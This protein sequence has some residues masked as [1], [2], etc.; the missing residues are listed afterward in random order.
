MRVHHG[1]SMYRT[2]AILT[3]PVLI[4]T[5]CG[6]PRLVEV[7]DETGRIARAGTTTDRL[8]TG[9]W[10]YFHAN[11]AKKAEG[12]WVQDKQE[13]LWTWWNDQGQVEIRGSYLHGLRTGPWERFHPSGS[14]SATG[15]YQ[16][17][18][19]HGLWT[20]RDPAGQMRSRGTFHRG[21]ERGLWQLGDEHAG[22][23]WDGV[24]VGPW[25]YRNPGGTPILVELP[26]P[27]GQTARWVLQDGVPV[28]EVPG[29]GLRLEWPTADGSL[30]FRW[31]QGDQGDEGRM[32]VAGA[33]PLPSALIPPPPA[34]S[35]PQLP[36]AAPVPVVPTPE[37]PV[38]RSPSPTQPALLTERER[39]VAQ[40]LISTYT[41]GQNPF[42]VSEYEVSSGP[43]QVGG[44]PAG[45]SLL[46]RVLPQQR[47]LSSTG[48][49][50]DLAA[51]QRPT[52]VVILRGFS[53]QVCI[54]CATQTAAIGRQ[55]E[56]F[57]T[58]GVDVLVVYPGPTEAVPVFVEA[59]KSLRHESLPMPIGLDVSL[60]LV[61]GL[62]IEENL[63][64]PTSLII[65]RTGII[66]Y[67]Y[68]G[69]TG[70]DRPSVDDLLRNAEKLGK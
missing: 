30:A 69:K 56:R 42:G 47:F 36:V 19:Q 64:R 6:G 38:E 49:V 54:Y 57:R 12:P 22:L 55:I 46:G 21:V 32:A 59:V 58:A 53:G 11:G 60:L 31:R 45:Q 65:D 10:V 15:A 68:V 23:Y 25:W 1:E 33:V 66:R 3:I 13:G 34:A 52:V 5:G 70:A 63:A 62:G 61:R 37:L 44:D 16:D 9:P 24:R 41:H 67:A 17:D 2:L 18:R 51:P 14:S 35:L 7:R 50:I 43:I 20:Y 39:E 40:E 27:A 48:R 8:Q 29:L 26:P 4:L 28:W